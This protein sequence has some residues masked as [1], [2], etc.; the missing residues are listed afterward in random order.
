MNEFA[1]EQIEAVIIDED[2]YEFLER[3]AILLENNPE[4]NLV[5]AKNKA[6]KEIR[7]RVLNG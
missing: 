1:R 4:M 5:H 7:L 6:R 3:L 2:G